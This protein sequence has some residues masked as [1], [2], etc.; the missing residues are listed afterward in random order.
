MTRKKGAKVVR[1]I[2]AVALGT[3]TLGAA[4]AAEKVKVGLMLPYTGTYAALGTAITNG[5]KQYVAEQGGTLGGR[6][7]EYF[8]V[9]DE[10]DPAKATENASKLVKRDNVDVLV[11]T[12]HSGVALAMAKV[13]R[14]TKTLLI[15]PNA[16]ADELT[17]PLCAPNVF[18]TSFTNWQPAYGMGKVA[19]E[20]GHKN[21]VTLTWKYAAGEQAVGGFKEAFE[22]AGGKIAKE[23][24]L[25]FPNV[26]FQAYL[27]EIANLKPDAVFVFFAGGGAAK[28][29]RDYDA[30]GL[31]K[32]IPLYASGFL[33][34]GTLD[35]MGGAGEGL[36]TTLH[37]AD[38]LTNAK[39]TA[40]RTKYATSYKM[41]PDVYAVQGY[42]AAQLLRVGLDAVK[43]GKLEQPAM[44][45]AM[46]AAKIDS[47]RGAFTL[48]K[49]HNPVQ[50]I[51][52]RKAEGR[53]NKLVGVAEK[54]L[55]DPARGCRM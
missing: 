33:T 20:R 9:D 50:D 18:R 21:V 44:I 52:L 5:F 6:E 35:A 26:E 47:P 2:A 1:S 4:Q 54:A 7:V 38:G 8:V 22:K 40:F 12:V 42:D 30:A 48:S 51:Y 15:V 46:E 34:D 41:Q 29:V 31:K 23:L 16:G 43:G 11:G 39:D 28:F 14:D 13:A 37:Y 17:G 53:D 19:A 25:P 24:Y 49:A 36:L 3:L 10:S 32:T 27:T 45:K 55:A